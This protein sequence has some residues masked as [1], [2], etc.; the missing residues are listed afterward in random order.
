MD[1]MAV[2]LDY[3]QKDSQIPTVKQ[4]LGRATPLL[5]THTVVS[6]QFKEIAILRPVGEAKELFLWWQ[7]GS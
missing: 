6:G 3:T 5:W 7:L 1:F 4:G 2:S